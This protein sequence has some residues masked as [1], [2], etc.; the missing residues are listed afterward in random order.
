MIRKLFDRFVYWRLSK[1]LSAAQKKAG[2]WRREANRVLK[3]INGDYRR[4]KALSDK[5]AEV[6]TRCEKKTERFLAKVDS[7]LEEATRVIDQHDEVQQALN[8]ELTILREM[9]LPGMALSNEAL[10]QQIQT[11]IDL[12]VQQ[13][14]AA[15]PT[16]STDDGF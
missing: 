12:M 9:T 14:V 10:R 8:Q 11:H 3:I 15:S 5:M 2:R 1:N 13:Q 4:W 6:F 7:D 16:K